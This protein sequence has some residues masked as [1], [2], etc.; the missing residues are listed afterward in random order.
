MLRAQEKFISLASFAIPDA[1]FVLL[2]CGSV[3]RPFLGLGRTCG[4]G[5]A[6]A[7]RYGIAAVGEW[8]KVKGLSSLWAGE[9]TR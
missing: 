7:G 9:G 6:A 8:G 3:S 2:N 5:V 4:V 1:G